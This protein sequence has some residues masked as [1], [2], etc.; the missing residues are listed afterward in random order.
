MRDFGIIAWRKTSPFFARLVKHYSAIFAKDRS[1][2][3]FVPLAD[4]LAKLGMTDQATTLLEHGVGEKPNSRVARILL[5]RLYYD[6]GDFGKSCRLLE[7]VVERWPGVLGAVT[8]LCR[9]YEQEGKP[10]KAEL[11][12]RR[13]LDYYPDTPS[14]KRLAKHYELPVEEKELLFSIV[15]DQIPAA[16]K[17]RGTRTKPKPGAVKS[18]KRTTAAPIRP[19]AKRVGPKTT[20]A[21]V[22]QS[23]VAAKPVLPR[24]PLHLTHLPLPGDSP[25]E[26]A[27]E[28]QTARPAM[29]KISKSRVKL[30][31]MLNRIT[32]MKSSSGM[33]NNGK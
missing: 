30:E 10:V 17:N 31:R 8:L 23:K 15:E 11:L 5:A 32:E 12:S 21:Q 4:S 24:K 25:V 33:I 3:I 2:Y 6:R 22:K 18:V 19:I 26:I 20:Q 13:L 29:K 14:I 1:S 9:V 7:E 28:H 27:P 16:K